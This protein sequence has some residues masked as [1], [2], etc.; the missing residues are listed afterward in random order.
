MTQINF[1]LDYNQ[2][3]DIISNSVANDL[4][5]EMLKTIF[6]QLIKKARN[7]TDLLFWYQIEKV[8]SWYVIYDILL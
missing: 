3:P 2:I 1:S 6:N 7:G 4:A 5:K 8:I